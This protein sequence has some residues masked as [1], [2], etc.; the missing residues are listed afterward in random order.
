MLSLSLSLSLSLTLSL[1]H[2]PVKFLVSTPYRLIYC[3]AL[4]AWAGEIIRSVS[5]SSQFIRYKDN[6]VL[7][8][9]DFFSESPT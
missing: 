9:I 5:D 3:L 8:S 4:S 2:S 1:S 7:D 6:N